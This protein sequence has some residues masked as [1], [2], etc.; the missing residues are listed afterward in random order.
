MHTTST[1]KLREAAV[2]TRGRLAGLRGPSSL[3]PASLPLP[4]RHLPVGDLHPDA[5]L[6]AVHPGRGVEVTPV[7]KG[8]VA[9]VTHSV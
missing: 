9:E 6:L 4:V 8:V 5:A 3:S 2:T 1:V 7:A